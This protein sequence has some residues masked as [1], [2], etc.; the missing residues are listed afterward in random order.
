LRRGITRLGRILA[1]AIRRLIDDLCLPSHLAISSYETLSSFQV[2]IRVFSSIF[3]ASQLHVFFN[4]APFSKNVKS[5]L[6]EESLDVRCSVIEAILTCLT[7]GMR[8]LWQ[9]ACMTASD[10]PKPFLVIREKSSK[11]HIHFS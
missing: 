8:G 2:K 3:L 6:F 11:F 4:K 5:S 1:F 10:T 7:R 9:V